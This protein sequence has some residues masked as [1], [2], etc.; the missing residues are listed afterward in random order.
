MND[1]NQILEKEFKMVVLTWTDTESKAGWHERIEL[2]DYVT[3]PCLIMKSVGW[4]IYNSFN[5]VVLAMTCGED[6]S[7]ELLKIPWAVISD[8]RTVPDDNGEH[9]R[10]PPPEYL[11]TA[12]AMETSLQHILSTKIGSNNE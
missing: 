6:H 1:N 4:L 10:Y 12:S 2:E 9:Y 11:K 3:K 7:G 5:H 8:L